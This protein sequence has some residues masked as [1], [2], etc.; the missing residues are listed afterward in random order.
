[1]TLPKFAYGDPSRVAEM[2]EKYDCT[3][4][5]HHTRL[6]GVEFC[7]KEKWQGVDNMKRCEQYERG[8]N[9]L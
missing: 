3:G 6:W 1:M 4:C 5:R 9:G 2:M 7:D 8:M